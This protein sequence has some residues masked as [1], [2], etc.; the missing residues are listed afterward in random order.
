MMNN[1]QNFC[2]PVNIGNPEEHSILDLAKLI[3]NL[4]KSKSEIIFQPLP[5][6]DPVKRR[7]DI[8]LAKKILNWQPEI[9]TE[10]GILKTIEYF[11]QQH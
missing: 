11:K 10:T 3:I 8:T 7:P 2:G 1:T 9:S 6:D 4:T 5:S